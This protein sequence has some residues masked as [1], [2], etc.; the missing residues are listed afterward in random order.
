MKISSLGTAGPSTL[1]PGSVY[2]MRFGAWGSTLT[3][4][5]A[6]TA[7][8]S[9]VDTAFPGAGSIGLNIGKSAAAAG[10]QAQAFGAVSVGNYPIF[11]IGV[12]NP[13]DGTTPRYVP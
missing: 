1:V 13:D 5:V 4:T 7:I 6:G 11:I 3:L 9:A 2:A 12:H 10:Y 8:I